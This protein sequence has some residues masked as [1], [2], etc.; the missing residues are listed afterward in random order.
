MLPEIVEEALAKE[1]PALRRRA[2]VAGLALLAALPGVPLSLLPESSRL[3][4]LLLL[5]AFL[6]FCLALFVSK[7]AKHK[8]EIKRLEAAMKVEPFDPFSAA[9]EAKKMGYEI[10]LTCN[11]PAVCQRSPFGNH[12]WICTVCGTPQPE[13]KRA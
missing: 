13:K 4:T 6:A 8:M 10:C 9:K 7:A 2:K 12:E 11:P 1:E 5:V 3:P